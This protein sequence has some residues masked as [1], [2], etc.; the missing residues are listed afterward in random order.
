MTNNTVSSVRAFDVYG[1]NR[2]GKHI[3]DWT[4]ETEDVSGVRWN[5]TFSA[6]D[7]MGDLD[8]FAQALVRNHRVAQSEGTLESEGFVTLHCVYVDTTDTYRVEFGTVFSA[9]LTE[10]SFDRIN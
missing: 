6:Y 5:M 2:Q 7:G 10:F 1:V 8:E 3:T 4:V 9:P